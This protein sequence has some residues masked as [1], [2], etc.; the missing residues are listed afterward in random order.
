[1]LTDALVPV[2]QRLRCPLHGIWGAMDVLY[3]QRLPLVEQVLSRAPGFVSLELLS[4][5]G[6]WVQFEE[7]EAFDAALANAI[8]R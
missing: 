1:M 4:Q 7:A 2:L 8:Q 6:H 3:R 5:A